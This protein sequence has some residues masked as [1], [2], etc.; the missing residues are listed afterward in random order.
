MCAVKPLIEWVLEWVESRVRDHYRK[1]EPGA[2][3][4]HGLKTQIPG[5]RKNSRKFRLCKMLDFT[6]SDTALK[7]ATFIW[8]NNNDGQF[9]EGYRYMLLEV[10]SLE[11]TPMSPTASIRPT[12]RDWPAAIDC[13]INKRPLPR[14]RQTSPGHCLDLEHIPSQANECKTL[15]YEAMTYQ[16]LSQQSAS[17]FVQRSEFAE[18]WRTVQYGSREPP[19]HTL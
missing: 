17:S 6:R 7:L 14:S 11:T 5:K 16:I 10:L 13:F 3:G 12:R 9:A 8:I 18:F 15:A 19:L 2:S 1:P 4:I